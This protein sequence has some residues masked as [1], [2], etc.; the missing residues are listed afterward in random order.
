MAIL[1]WIKLIHCRLQ[2]PHN[3]CGSFWKYNHHCHQRSTVRHQ[4]NSKVNRKHSHYCLY[5]QGFFF[6]L[7]LLNLV[8]KCTLACFNKCDASLQCQPF[9][10]QYVEPPRACLPKHASG[11]NRLVRIEWNMNEAAME[12]T[13][14]TSLCRTEADQQVAQGKQTRQFPGFQVGKLVGLVQ[15]LKCSC[16]QQ[17]LRRRN[18]IQVETVLIGWVV[19]PLPFE[20]SIELGGNL[21]S[22]A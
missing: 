5:R 2:L 1:K 14:S 7:Y 20:G 6:L 15:L 17:S 22:S 9:F 11:W 21:V 10:S 4:K 19:I 3:I 12:H 16:S 18:C 8:Q 13:Y